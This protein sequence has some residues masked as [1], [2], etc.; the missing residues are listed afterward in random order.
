MGFV[1]KRSGGRGK[2]PL[3]PLQRRLGD[4][5]PLFV[6]WLGPRAA[7]RAVPLLVGLSA[8]GLGCGRLP[9][10]RDRAPMR[11]RRSLLRRCSG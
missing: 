6:L 1:E 3:G 7:R 2:C 5:V 9:S 4:P 11:M 8:A 10:P